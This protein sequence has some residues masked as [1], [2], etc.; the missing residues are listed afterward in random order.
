MVERLLTAAAALDY[1]RDRLEIQV[2]DD[3]TDNTTELVAETAGRLRREGIQIVHLTRAQRDGFKGGALAAGLTRAGGELIAIFDA[4]FVPPPD[5][6]RRVVPRFADPRLGCVQTRWGHLNRE[7]SPF[8][9]AQALGLDGHFIVEQTARSRSGLF[10]NFNGSGGVLRKSCI[11]DA[12]GW[13]ADT[14]TEDLDLSYR[15]QIRGWRIS[16]LPE[17]IVPAELPAQVSAFKSQQARWAQG[18]I[19]TAIK[20]SG[21]LLRSG[22]SW[23][24]KLEGII[25]L[26]SYLVHPL[27]LSMILLTLPVSSRPN[28]GLRMVPGLM[29]AAAGPPLLYGIAALAGGGAP[30]RRLRALPMLVLLGTGIA[31]SNT[32]AVLRALLRRRQVFQRTPKFDLRQSGDQWVASSYALE[33]DALTLAEA[34]LALFALAVLAVTGIRWGAGTW[35]L[36]YSGGFGYVAGTTVLQ[37]LQRRR[38]LATQPGSE[39]SKIRGR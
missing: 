12:G 6:L 31:L 27:M 5:F 29:V 35:M 39:D 28:W 33:A 21:L 16:Y 2:L 10:I 9:Q 18:S 17:V 38:W 20:L 26:T 7:Y 37:T 32:L 30:G 4:D 3:S 25:H 22:H 1:P 24:V 19:E 8:T 36:V 15:A 14:L 34:A 11:D 13:S 23:T